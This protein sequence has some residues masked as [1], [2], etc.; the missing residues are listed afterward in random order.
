[1]GRLERLILVDRHLLRVERLLAADDPA[2]A[3]RLDSEVVTL[4]PHEL[5]FVPLSRSP[6]VSRSQA[7]RAAT[8]PLM[9]TVPG[10]LPHAVRPPRAR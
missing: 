10:Q 3:Q 4:Q 2:G 7:A 5:R 6:P 8:G 1:M 9:R